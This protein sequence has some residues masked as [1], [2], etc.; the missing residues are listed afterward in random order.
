VLVRGVIDTA[1]AFEL[2]VTAEGVERPNQL[3]VLR[4][5]GCD[6]LQGFFIQ[7]PAPAAD[8]D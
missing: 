1:H 3:H 2:T 6:D 8:L 5:L 4:D 7:R